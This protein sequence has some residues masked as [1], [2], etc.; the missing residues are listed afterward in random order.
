VT[1]RAR[2]RDR[3]VYLSSHPVL[4][5][6]LAMLRSRPV[7]RAGG[8]V[9]VNDTDVF[10]ETLSR[11]PLDRTDPRS[12][13]GAARR[14]GIGQVLFDQDGAEHR[15]GRRE[16]SEELGQS[17]ISKLRTAWVGVLERRVPQ[18]ADGG[19]DVVALA[20]ELSGTTAAALLGCSA[21]PLA[22]AA[23]AQ[24]AAAITVRGELPGRR[25]RGR[26]L[27]RAG[28]EL[29]DLLGDSPWPAGVA[30]MTAIAAINTTVAAIPRAVA[31]CAD[32]HLWSRAE[33]PEVRPRL[34]VELLRVLAPSPILPRVAAADGTVGG[35]PVRSGDRLVLVARHAA[36]SYCADPD[37]D[38][39]QP[40]STAH[41]VFG[42]GRHTCPGT[43]LARA[44]LEDVLAMLAPYRP[45]V[46]EARVDRRAALPSWRRLVVRGGA[47]AN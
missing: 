5:T 41:L 16:L 6:L 23:A 47:R 40:P 37:P 7:W 4:L 17:G 21:D 31:W 26:S 38:H 35:C 20:T 42:A 27:P 9:V 34:V 15:T 1:S 18:V 36:R 30:T 11:F 19:L 3:L 28:T 33:D 14:A 8:V 13:G 29:M 2:R 12:T 43:A 45:V 25:L 46:S 44:Q 10:L 32:D 22:L 39:P 24:R